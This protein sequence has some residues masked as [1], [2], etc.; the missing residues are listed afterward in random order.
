MSRTRIAVIGGSGLAEA[1]GQEQVESRE[2]DTPFGKP[3]SA[4]TLHQFDGTEVVFLKRHGDGHVH[5]PG[6]VP[7]RANIYA[8][9]ALGVT[10]I[11]ASGATGSLREEIRPG[12]IAIT[13]QA[14]DKTT[15]RA[16]TFYEGAAVHVEFAEPCCPVLRSW[17]IKAGKQLDGITV[18]DSATYVCMEGPAFSTR[19]ES[20]M[21][22]A[23][24]ADLIGMT[25]LPEARLAREAEIAYAHIALPT[26][27]DCWRPREAGQP[28]E[29]L[30]EIIGNLQ[31]ATE[32]SIR[33]I[34][35]ALSDIS[36][37]EKTPSPA[38]DALALAIWSDKAAIPR[39]EI[40]RL[41]VL[42]GRHFSGE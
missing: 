26:D 14:I 25:L 6:A 10:H 27:Y 29:L 30:K 33:L 12:D 28:E 13:D 36:A 24:G 38:H 42:W 21:H 23:W 32:N 3:S 20:E 8:L 2:L 34:K 9:K 16:R 4:V 19:A 40:D 1:F 7:Y 22:R 39:E 17:L 15:S 18:H 5:N 41:H 35:A 11:V 37:L 31:Q